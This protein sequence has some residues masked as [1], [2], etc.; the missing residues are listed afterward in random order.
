MRPR[1]VAHVKGTYFLTG[2]VGTD[3]R[4]KISP[5]HHWLKFVTGWVDAKFGN[6]GGGGV[7]SLGTGSVV[8]FPV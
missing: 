5:H 2:R 4:G 7:L 3:L 6:S 8:N 1:H